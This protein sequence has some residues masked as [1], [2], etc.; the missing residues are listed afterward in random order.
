MGLKLRY[1]L[2]HDVSAPSVWGALKSFY[3]G[4]E[5]EPSDDSAHNYQ[6][7]EEDGRWTLLSWDGGWEWV[8]RRNAQLHVSERLRCAGLLVFVYDGEYWGYE[9]FENGQVKNR[10]VQVPEQD[11]FPGDS[12]IGDPT[13]IASCFPEISAES[14]APYLA[15][16]TAG[17]RRLPPRPGDQFGPFDECSVVDFLRTLGVRVDLRDDYVTPAARIYKQF[18]IR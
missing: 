15:Q 7:H 16:K 8:T 11:W 3:R 14:I 9:L 17:A 13:L 5:L 4:R 18:A 12:C 6:L 10:F 1:N 2:F